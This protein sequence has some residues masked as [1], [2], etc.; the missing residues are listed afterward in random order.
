MG[1]GT[2]MVRLCAMYTLKKKGTL[3]SFWV[4]TGL[5]NPT[6]MFYE[7][8]RFKFCP[9]NPICEVGKEPS[10]EEELGVWE[11]SLEKIF[12][13][14]QEALK[15]MKSAPDKLWLCH[16]DAYLQQNNKPD[17]LTGMIL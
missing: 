14:H 1:L 16:A 13:E 5:G 2:L 10:Q 3:H 17:L 7:K 12:G 6:K 8:L 15:D 9:P 11:T 4:Q